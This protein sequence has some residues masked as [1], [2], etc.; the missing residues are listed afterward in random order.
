MRNVYADYWQANVTTWV[1]GG[2]LN[3][4]PVTECGGAGT[5]LCPVLVNAA[6]GWFLDPADP[7]AVIVDPAPPC[8]DRPPPPM[9]SRS[10]S[11][12]SRRHRLRR[13]Y[14]LHLTASG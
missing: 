1:T 10:A 2:R 5:R 4:R 12:A 9:G 13:T 7:T 6:A 14:P 3:V 8:R 11:F